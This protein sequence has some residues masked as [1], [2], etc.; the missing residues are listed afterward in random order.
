MTKH[1]AL[2]LLVSVAAAAQ[3]CELQKAAVGE[4]CSVASDC[5]SDLCLDGLCQPANV[6]LTC[7]DD[8]LE[9]NDSKDEAYR[10]DADREYRGLILCPDDSDWFVVR[11]HASEVPVTVALAGVGHEPPGGLVLRNT[12]GEAIPSTQT[13]SEGDT[14]RFM[15][16][17][18]LDGD[19][20]LEI[21]KGTGLGGKYSLRVS[22]EA[23]QAAC[24]DDYPGTL[25][26]AQP[27]VRDQGHVSIEGTVCPGED[28][29]SWTQ[30]LG[31][32]DAIVLTVAFEEAD[33]AW[34]LT[35][36]EVGEDGTPRTKATATPEEPE[37]EFL[38]PGSEIPSTYLV[39]LMVEG[40]VEAPLHYTMTGRV[41][42]N[43]QGEPANDT[44]QSTLRAAN[45]SG[46]VHQ[47]EQGDMPLEGVLALED[48]DWFAMRVPQ[49]WNLALEG[50]YDLGEGVEL[51]VA[52][53]T[54]RGVIQG[55]PATGSGGE[56]D[57]VTTPCQSG[58]CDV[59]VRLR[60][61]E[62]ARPM[63][64]YSLTAHAYQDIPP[65]QD[66]GLEDNDD[67]D[68]ATGLTV[69]L[70]V[71]PDRGWSSGQLAMCPG[72][73]DWFM[74][75]NLVQG[76]VVRVELTG[77]PSD[78]PTARFFG[79]G[80]VELQAEVEVVDERATYTL[81]VVESGDHLFS[82]QDNR[83]PTPEDNS[84]Q[85]YSLVVNVG[86][87]CH[88]EDEYE[89]NDDLGQASL[90][91]SFPVHAMVCAMDDD[92]F[93]IREPIGSMV[94]ITV[95][96][97][98]DGELYLY[99]YSGDWSGHTMI[100]EQW[101]PSAG[102]YSISGDV[103]TNPQD[104]ADEDDLVLQVIL[105]SGLST[106]YVVDAVVTPPATLT[107]IQADLFDVHCA[108][109]HGPGHTS[110]VELDTAEHSRQTLVNVVSRDVP[111]KLL[112]APYDAG[113]SALIDLLTMP[114]DDPGRMPLG[115]ARV[116]DHL[117]R[118]LRSWILSGA[119]GAD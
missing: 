55:D 36:M 111:G 79:P 57:M 9:P 16:R 40:L 4:P 76:Q 118:R 119:R 48:E 77:D 42:F 34:N 78:L 58:A 106:D 107:D 41:L 61:Q 117:I 26:D 74:L 18:T 29:D 50:T 86:G 10:L 28:V 49:G 93:T 6:A 97:T 7:Q 5:E 88:G 68:H 23:P 116:P 114:Q 66:D 21:T 102:A 44:A 32:R 101:Q 33:V 92:L 24:E 115:R 80:R 1:R 39:S 62:G 17:I 20:F 75:P 54:S 83:E 98:G 47:L 56:F 91:G 64:S 113:M 2:F 85:T 37:L 15:Y 104:P 52:L 89:D 82:V 19:Y 71:G 73:P 65:C 46:G 96:P 100:A 84:P 25:D 53:A 30:M 90:V 67:Q 103:G 108:S 94:D 105:T 109:C 51:E 8:P 22:T 95:T 72:D 81:H 38:A 60:A 13:A 14:S 12:I 63:G 45:E 31:P 70:G 110:G 112:V 87:A 35:L 43:D 11:L 69:P 27:L 3:G 99:L 59:L